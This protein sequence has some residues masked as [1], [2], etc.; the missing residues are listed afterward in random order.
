[1]RAAMQKSK[2]IKE[3]LA[4]NHNRL[5]ALTTRL[6]ERS[7]VL[8]HVVAVL[9]AEVAGALASAGLD[10]G[11][12]TLG[13]TG[14]VW[15]SRLRYVTDTLRKRVGESLGQEITSVK[16]KVVPPSPARQAT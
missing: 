11:Q 13:V 2:S 10:G 9:P 3:L 6:E 4:G 15:A 1:M 16:I 14:A 8:S 7:T 5:N 12:L